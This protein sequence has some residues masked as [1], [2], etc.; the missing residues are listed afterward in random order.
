MEPVPKYS[1]RNEKKKGGPD[2]DCK[3][4]RSAKLIDRN[5]PAWSAPRQPP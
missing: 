3:K 1:P 5:I 4:K 2:F